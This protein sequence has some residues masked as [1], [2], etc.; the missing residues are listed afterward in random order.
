MKYFFQS[1]PYVRDFGKD[2]KKIRGQKRSFFH[3]EIMALT[4]EVKNGIEL[5]EDV[6]QGKPSEVQTKH[7][8]HSK[9]YV[10]YFGKGFKK[11][12]TRKPSISILARPRH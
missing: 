1:N 9:L 8:Y 12:R 11:I 6:S 5:L 3:F 4:H 7:F 10:S 2:F